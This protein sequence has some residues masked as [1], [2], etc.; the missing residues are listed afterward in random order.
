MPH[1]IFFPGDNPSGFIDFNYDIATC[2]SGDRLWDATPLLRYQSPTFLNTERMAEGTEHLYFYFN[3]TYFGEEEDE[4]YITSVNLQ[5][6]C[7]DIIVED[8]SYE[9]SCEIMGKSAR[10][11]VINGRTAYV[12]WKLDRY[13]EMDNWTVDSWDNFYD[14]LTDFEMHFPM[15]ITVDYRF[16]NESNPDVHGR[17]QFCD[18]I[19]YYVDAGR[20]N[21]KEVL[22]DWLLYDFV[23]VLDEIIDQTDIWMERL[24]K[25]LEYA[26]MGCMISFFTKFLTKFYRNF[27]CR[28]EEMGKK[29]SF[30]GGGA[31]EEAACQA[32][33]DSYDGH[34]K[35]GLSIDFK[36]IGQDKLSDTCLEVCYPKCHSAWQT[37]STW[38]SFFRWTCDRVFGHS[39]PSGWTAKEDP[40]KLLE[41]ARVGSECTDD[42]STKG[43]PMR[44]V[45]CRSVERKYSLEGHFGV[46]DKCVEIKADGTNRYNLYRISDTPV[47]G[48][49]YQ[50]I[51][52]KLEAGTFKYEY[53]IKQ[54]ETSYLTFQPKTCKELC[55]INEK[56]GTVVS[57]SQGGQRTIKLEETIDK[58]DRAALCTTPN[59]CLSYEGAILKDDKGE[60]FLIKYPYTEGYTKDCFYNVEQG[61]LF[62]DGTSL[63]YIDSISGD[64][65]KRMECC[66]L[67]GSADV[68]SYYYT[69]KD[70]ESKDSTGYPDA[71][72]ASAWD[73]MAWSYRYS[74]IN[75]KAPKSLTGK[76][77]DSY[78]PN[79]YIAG[80]DQ[81]ACFGQNHWLFGKKELILDPKRDHLAAFQ[82]VD[83]GGIYNRLQFIRNLATMLKSCLIQVR[84][85][86]TADSGVCKEM[87]SQYV[88]SF[89]WRVISWVRSGC[90]PFGSDTAEGEESW[91]DY[92]RAGTGA[93][94]DSVKESQEELKNEYGNADLN[95]MFGMNEE[96]LVRKVCMAAFGYDWDI[97]SESFMD[98]AYAAPFATFVQTVPPAN[99]QYL[100]FDPT[101]SPA[102]SVY[103]YRA[104]WLINPGCD[105]DD[106]DV[107]LTCVSQDERNK[108]PGIRCDKVGAPDG[109]NCPCLY[110]S[111]TELAKVH[112]P[113]Y[114][115]GDSL[116][117]NV[118]ED[119]DHTM[120]PSGNR[121]VRSEYR[122]DHLKFVIDARTIERSGGD[123]SKCFPDGH[124][125]GG[126]GV[127]YFPI[128]DETPSDLATCS[129]EPV[130][131]VFSCDAGASFL[132]PFGDAY[133]EA[134]KLDFN[135]VLERND[136]ENLGTD[137]ESSV[138]FRKGQ[139]IKGEITYYKDE[140]SKCLVVYLL[141]S[142]M[143]SIE[144]TAVYPLRQ[145]DTGTQTQTFT[146]GY[147]VA[148]SDLVIGARRITVTSPQEPLE[149]EA[150]LSL[151]NTDWSKLPEGEEESVT[152]R[153]VDSNGD[154]I[155]GKENYN[156]ID[157]IQINNGETQPMGNICNSRNE[158]EIDL[159][160]IKTRILDVSMAG[161]QNNAK[162]FTV[163]FRKE[164]EGSVVTNEP[165]FYLHVDLRN[166]KEGYENCEN[167]VDSPGLENS[168]VVMRN[169]RKEKFEIPIYVRQGE[170]EGVC[171]QD[172]N[173]ITQP[174]I[175]MEATEIK[176]NTQ[177]NCDSGRYCVNDVCRKY[178]ECSISDNLDQSNC[179]CGSYN[180][181]PPYLDKYN[182]GYLDGS[183]DDFYNRD[184]E[185]A[186]E[187]AKK[188]YQ[189]CY[190]EKVD[191][192]VKCHNKVKEDDGGGGSALIKPEITWITY[193]KPEESAKALMK[194]GGRHQIPSNDY[195]FEVTLKNN[196]DIKRLSILENG[197]IRT[198]DYNKIGNAYKIKW[199]TPDLGSVSER[200]IGIEIEVEQ[201]N[202]QKDK[203]PSTGKYIFGTVKLDTS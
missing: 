67:T 163:V 61:N 98:V 167:G 66:C 142:S 171:K 203:W 34:M 146:T 38:Y 29:A 154:G 107:Y 17:Q 97:S 49:V 20:V 58:K 39:S 165:R 105:F 55:Q 133:L 161:A 59:K 168:L 27:Q 144:R 3:F 123:V 101:T 85:T 57:G 6:A 103:E 90:S 92:I 110:L 191:D 45:N 120:V 48:D 9:H 54:T 16:K 156:D 180:A 115:D 179:I 181:G 60:D 141:D 134:V 89:V 172:G 81:S 10:A 46:N 152:L 158:C 96:G 178:P 190:R 127:F 147:T 194:E 162:V 12:V 155:I 43:T 145:S 132:H 74:L 198:S 140:K 15:R 68:D 71:K 25:I 88:C 40:N 75:W 143:N 170:A 2:W 177:P 42:Q 109:Y 53:A 174:C 114:Y 82:C 69:Y 117:Q 93:M 44:T 176:E 113:I 126:E 83:I 18:T 193:Y 56:T 41:K 79:R 199:T 197:N 131:G 106:Y 72:P 14:S 111:D 32:C 119:M 125:Q 192:P 11:E 164:T 77:R 70:I 200:D 195:F 51:E 139:Q 153:F 7:D 76:V 136:L 173:T 112:E 166:P 63:T 47:E 130:T 151:T 35:N 188:K 157:Q 13:E 28:I 137:R 121:I 94:L 160:R 30:L 100:T 50:L 26:A 196:V 138:S 187:E 102:K 73:D 118:L 62:R 36:D 24:H 116:T 37:E 169:N 159:G 129:M 8:P 95:K 86:G 201:K 91:T 175:C 22:P 185:H 135:R 186:T 78:D 122:Y 23:D 31:I 108:Y 19:T 84:I 33:I 99:R 5:S 183:K 128:I 21:F 4:A 1:R 202:G 149:R 80:R 124:Y 182:C 87:F 189:Y 184:A 148:E 104:G 150:G 64:P 52:E 65:E